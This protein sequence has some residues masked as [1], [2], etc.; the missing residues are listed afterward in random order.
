[1]NALRWLRSSAG[2]PSGGSSGD[3]NATKT[4]ADV[5]KD[6]RRRTDQLLR[7]QKRAGEIV[8]RND[9]AAGQG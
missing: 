9:G 7:D 8:E 1:M 4:K 2:D 5:L 3:P 6:T